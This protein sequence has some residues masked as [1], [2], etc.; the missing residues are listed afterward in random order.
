LD[1]HIGV[2]RRIN[3]VNAPAKLITFAEMIESAAP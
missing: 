1:I 2:S 3:E